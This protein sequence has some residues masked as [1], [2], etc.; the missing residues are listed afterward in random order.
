MSELYYKLFLKIYK[1][2]NNNNC[3]ICILGDVY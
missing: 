1:D 2:N 3:K